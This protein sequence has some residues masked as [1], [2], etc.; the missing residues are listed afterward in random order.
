MKKLKKN[1]YSN[2]EK[3]LFKNYK[4]LKSEEK[5]LEIF[6]LQFRLCALNESQIASTN[7]KKI[8]KKRLRFRLV[9]KF[10]FT[11]IFV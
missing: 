4:F 9:F 11:F 5:T 2:F 7:L 6:Q 3:K 1:L 8:L 10:F